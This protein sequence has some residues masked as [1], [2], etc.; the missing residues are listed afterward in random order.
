MSDWTQTLAANGGEIAMHLGVAPLPR[1]Q[2]VALTVD[3]PTGTSCFL[4]TAAE[5]RGAAEALHRMATRVEIAEIR[6]LDAEV[7]AGPPGPSAA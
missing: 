5:A 7:N 2:Q 4:L 1:G 3:W 6:E